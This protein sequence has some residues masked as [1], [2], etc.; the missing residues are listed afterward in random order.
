[1]IGNLTISGKKWEFKLL[2]EI[3]PMTK[4]RVQDYKSADIFKGGLL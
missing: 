1:M 2:Q 3:A 4:D